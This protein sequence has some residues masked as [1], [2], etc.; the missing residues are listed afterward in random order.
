MNL[1]ADSSPV[2]QITV[3]PEK[4]LDFIFV[5]IEN[6]AKPARTLTYKNGIG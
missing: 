5:K 4:C 6:L 1:K 3:K 2:L